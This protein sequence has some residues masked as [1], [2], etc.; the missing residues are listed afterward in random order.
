VKLNVAVKQ[1][2]CQEQQRLV[3]AVPQAGPAG[4]KPI[5]SGDLLTC[6]FQVRGPRGWRLQECVCNIRMPRAR[7]HSGMTLASR[8]TTTMCSQ[9]NCRPC[10]APQAIVLRDRRCIGRLLSPQVELQ[11]AGDARSGEAVA[12]VL[13]LE[14]SAWQPASRTAPAQVQDVRIAI[15]D[16]DA[17]SSISLNLIGRHQRDTFV[18]PVEHSVSG[19]ELATALSLHAQQLEYIEQQRAKHQSQRHDAPAPCQL[20]V[21]RHHFNVHIGECGCLPTLQL[22]P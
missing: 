6:T 20:R 9:L 16:T 17:S 14:F 7:S 2:I 4:G 22:P 10:L 8:A 11:P 3:F 5:C 13:K 19:K 12:Q 21:P 18:L 1:G 15:N